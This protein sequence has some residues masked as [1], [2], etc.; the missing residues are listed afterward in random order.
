M[1]KNMQEY[2]KELSEE[3]INLTFDKNTYEKMI[4]EIAKIIKL[5]LKSDT[6]IEKIK[7][8]LEEHPDERQ[9]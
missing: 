6:K 3:Y 9:R 2:L 8:V 5:R 4:S 7:K 1:E